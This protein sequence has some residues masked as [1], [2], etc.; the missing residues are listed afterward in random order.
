MKHDAIEINGIT[1]RIEFN[2]NTISEFI[3]STG[4]SLADLDKMGTMTPRQITS[5]IYCAI[6]EGCRMDGIEF[7][8]T[9]ADFGAAIGVNEISEILKIYTRQTSVSVAT[10]KPKKK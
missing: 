1:Y 8:F 4:L 7:P 3:E 10:V 9:M 6:K 5:L 2:W